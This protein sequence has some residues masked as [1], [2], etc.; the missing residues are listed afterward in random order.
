MLLCKHICWQSRTSRYYALVIKLSLKLLVDF[1]LGVCGQNIHISVLRVG[2]KI[3]CNRHLAAM[4]N[5]HWETYFVVFNCLF[6][7]FAY[8]NYLICSLFSTLQTTF[9]EIDGS[10]NSHC[11]FASECYMCGATSVAIQNC[12][13]PPHYIRSFVA[14]TKDYHV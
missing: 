12:S 9:K 14:G 13:E 4:K 11:C 2:V 7:F 5:I 6:L 8:L 1:F 3:I 10:Y